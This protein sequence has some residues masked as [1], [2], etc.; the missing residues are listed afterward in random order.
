V[1]QD[2]DFCVLF[3]ADGTALLDPGAAFI[4]K[5]RITV[6]VRVD[7]HGPPL[8][9]APMRAT[10]GDS[11]AGNYFFIFWG[12]QLM[13]SAVYGSEEVGKIIM[14]MTI[15]L[16]FFGGSSSCVGRCMARRR[17]AR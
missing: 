8:P 13:C 4:Q 2:T 14:I 15:F 3:F 7:T 16:F 5:A 12:S 17:R 10:I 1:H 9:G 6:S 11:V